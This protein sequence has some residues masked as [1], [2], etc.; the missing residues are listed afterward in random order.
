[1]IRQATA[2]RGQAGSAVLVKS[3][4]RGEDVT[5]A[6]P[7][8][9]ARPVLIG[10]PA[11]IAARV[12]RAGLR[13]RPGVDVDVIDPESDARY[14]EYWTDYQ[15]LMGRHGVTPDM[16]KALLRRSTTTIGACGCCPAPRPNVWHSA[17]P[18]SS[19]SFGT[20]SPFS[21]AASSGSCR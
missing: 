13:F 21:K 14:R 6:G 11:V 17:S 4:R 9:L 8:R 2:A 20:A 5:P 15:R 19:P 12:A 16:A 7:E 1:M 3:I 10:R 18:T